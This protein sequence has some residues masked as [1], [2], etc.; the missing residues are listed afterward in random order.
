MNMKKTLLASLLLALTVMSCTSS[1]DM[2]TKNEADEAVQF[3]TEQTKFMLERA[4]TPDTLLNPCT[5]NGRG[6]VK[7]INPYD[8][9]SGFFPGTLWYLYALT[10][11]ASWSAYARRYL[12]WLEPVKDFTGSHDVGFMMGDSYGVGRR[13]MNTNSLVPDKPFHGDRQP[14]FGGE[15]NTMA[16]DEYAEILIQTA[17]SLCARY[18]E[19]ARVIRSWGRIGENQ[20]TVIIDNMMNLELLFEASR[21]SGDDTYRQI[22]IN[23]AEST[24]ANHFREDGSCY[25]VLEYNGADGT[26]ISKHTNQGL[27]DESVW[28]RGH[29]W[30]IYGFTLMYRYTHEQKYLD[31]AIGTFNF[32]RNHPNMPEDHVPYWDFDAPGEERDASS[33]A[34]I[35]SALYEMAGYVS[36]YQARDF[37]QYATSILRSL[38]SSDYRATV[39]ENGGFLLKHSVSS[40]PG[41]SEVNVPLNYADYY[42]LEAIWRSL[43]I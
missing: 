12:P 20:V 22:A 8:W 4:C 2:F 28:A 10:G 1:N 13:F 30:A 35:A 5:L 6:E 11:D 39:G 7:Y 25:H 17:K 14:S 29:A 43:Q 3:A 31:R 23:H 21:L 26:V 15:W 16:D 33:A 42:Y 27:A 24:L 41:R 40:K 9:R 34:I 18:V 36:A 19:D 32:L 38:S 37:R